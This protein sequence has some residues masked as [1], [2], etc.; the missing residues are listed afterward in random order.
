MGGTPDS[1]D[2]F[3]HRMRAELLFCAG[4][5]SARAGA[6]SGEASGGAATVG[7]GEGATAQRAFGD[8]AVMRH[9]D[10]ERL[11]IEV[12]HRLSRTSV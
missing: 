9:E 8:L 2:E 7:G 12:L 3:G 10:E 6:F 11:P 5:G 4:L 1:V